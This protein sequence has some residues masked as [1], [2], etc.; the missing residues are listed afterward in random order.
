VHFSPLHHLRRNAVAYLAL[1]VA[2]GGT[3]VAAKPLLTGADIQDG[4]IASADIADDSSNAAIAGVDVANDSLTGTDILE[5]SLGTVP[6]ADTLDG[7]DSNDF[8]QGTGKLRRFYTTD[9][10][11]PNDINH[12]LDGGIAA[13]RLTCVSGGPT[14]RLRGS[15]ENTSGGSISLWRERVAAGTL[16][17]DT[18]PASDFRPIFIEEALVP[19]ERFTIQAANASASVTWEGWAN[20]TGSTC[21]FHVN[22]TTLNETTQ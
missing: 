17:F 11:A 13:L 21:T 3:A 22:E 15:V 5:S 4:S 19:A 1:F 18:L 7:L 9:T 2:M 14:A 6:N 20:V 12:I 16:F 10:P 8:V